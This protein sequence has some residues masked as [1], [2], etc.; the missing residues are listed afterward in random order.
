MGQRNYGLKLIKDKGELSKRALEMNVVQ[1]P[2]EAASLISD[3]K[4]T[5]RDYPGT[6]CLAAP[7]IGQ[8]ARVFCI[9]FDGD[10]RAF[11]NPMISKT[12]G[13]HISREADPTDGKEY[14]VPRNDEI[15]AV[16]Q[17][18]SGLAQSNRFSGAAADVFQAMSNLLDGVLPSDFGLEVIPG[19]DE[20]SDEE[21]H[22]VILMYMDSL[23]ARDKAEREDIEADPK[24]KEIADAIKFMEKVQTGEIKIEKGHPIEKPEA[25]A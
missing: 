9:D 5:L 18:P 11:V 17:S 25:K 6:V 20:A 19:W 3:L 14:L 23:K 13:M 7:Q 2:K 1:R 10:V 24:L 4:S 16:Y 12:K 22:K 21:R 15:I 8:D